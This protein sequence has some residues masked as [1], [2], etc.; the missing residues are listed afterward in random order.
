MIAIKKTAAASILSLSLL[1]PGFVYADGMGAMNGTMSTT[2]DQGMK[3]DSADMPGMMMES[4]DYV[5]L[6]Q[7]ADALGYKVMWNAADRSIT[8]T[9]IG[10]N[11]DMGMGNKGMGMSM[12]T[13]KSMNMNMDVNMDSSMGMTGDMETDM[14][15]ASMYTVKVFLDS[16][17]IYIGMEKQMLAHAPVVMNGKACVT[18]DFIAKYLLA[19]FMMQSM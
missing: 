19:P 1:F 7:F 4:M 12:G 15:M 10:M 18:K 11:M 17:D 3:M 14:G 6:R 9:F 16:K 13:D 8:M 2:M 5:P